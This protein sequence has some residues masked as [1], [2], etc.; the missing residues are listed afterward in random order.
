MTDTTIADIAMEK[1]VIDNTDWFEGQED[2]GDSFK[3]HIAGIRGLGVFPVTTS[4][5]SQNVDP[6]S[7]VVRI[8]SGGTAGLE[9]INL[10]APPLNENG[11]NT[12]YLGSR[13]YFV[14]DTQTNPSD[15]VKIKN[16]G[17]DF[18]RLLVPETVDSIT[19]YNT[20]L[21]NF[22][23]ACVC[24]VWVADGWK[25]DSAAT[26]GSFN[27]AY[28]VDPIS[29]MPVAVTGTAGK[30][31]GIDPGA[32]DTVGKVKLGALNPLPTTDPLVYGQ[33]WIDAAAGF[34]VKQSQGE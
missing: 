16:D 18:C 33:L 23:G 28:R 10:T 20:V 12:D 24:M 34:A 17:V 4:G 31:V 15:V 25:L 3:A 27:G 32:G 11:I 21:L 19:R 7:K 14:L 29:I 22:A 13:V 5:V 1:T 6:K 9:L 8:T 26:D 2:G 30:D